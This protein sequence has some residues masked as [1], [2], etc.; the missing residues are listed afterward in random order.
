MT[1]KQVHESALANLADS[2]IV[3][4]I[5]QHDEAVQAYKT[6]IRILKREMRRRAKS[7]SNPER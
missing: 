4:L 3:R 7:I 6:E 5:A 1:K 2:Y